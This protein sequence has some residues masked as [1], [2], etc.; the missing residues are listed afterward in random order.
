VI[1]A[2]KRVL[3]L[4]IDVGHDGTAERDA[5]IAIKQWVESLDAKTRQ[6]VE[7]RLAGYTLTE[8]GVMFPENG[9]PVHNY[10]INRRIKALL[11]EYKSKVI[12]EK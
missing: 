7:A 10:V 8:I 4:G 5:G 12:G 3:S 11:S 6:I 1:L 9:K 2:G